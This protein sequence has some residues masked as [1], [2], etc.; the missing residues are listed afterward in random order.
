MAFVGING[1]GKSTSL[2]KVA[3]YLK[4]NGIKVSVSKSNTCRVGDVVHLARFCFCVSQ[5]GEYDCCSR[6]PRGSS[7]YPRNLLAT[8]CKDSILGD[9]VFFS[10][11]RVWW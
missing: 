9:G 6:S 4:E 8:S 3:Y 11:F 5:G 1:V 10:H 2:A 7:R